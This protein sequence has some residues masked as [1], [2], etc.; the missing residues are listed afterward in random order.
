[1]IRREASA[2]LFVGGATVICDYVVYRGLVWTGLDLSAAKAIGFIAGTCFAYFANKR[3]TFGHKTSRPGSSWRFMLLYTVTLTINVLVN[4]MMIAFA[5]ALDW[6]HPAQLAF[7]IATGISSVLNFIGMKFFV[8]I[9][10][11][12][13]HL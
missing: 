8:F 13:L 2:F 11:R 6:P 9:S 10:S 4:G 7:V 1:M 12:K 3:L 5:R